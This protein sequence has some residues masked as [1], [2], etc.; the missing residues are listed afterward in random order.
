MPGMNG[1]VLAKRVA[2]RCPDV[3]VLFMSGYTENTIVHHGVVVRG[4]EL[5]Q[6]PFEPQSLG[7]KVREVLDHAPPWRA[8][9]A[10]H[11]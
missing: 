8:R 3:R 1:A 11:E 4:V 2:E 7:Y 10:L 5:I 6:K 9:A